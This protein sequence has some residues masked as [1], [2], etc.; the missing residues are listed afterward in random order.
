MGAPPPVKLATDFSDD[1]ET[2]LRESPAHR[3]WLAAF[4]IDTYQ[5]SNERYQTFVSETGHESPS[6]SLNP[7]LSLPSHPV[8]GISWYDAAAYAAW[9]G[10][11]LPTEAEWEKAARGDLEQQTYPWGNQPNSGKECNAADKQSPCPWKDDSIDDGFPFTAPVGSYPPNEYGLYDM[12][13]NVWEWC[14]DDCRRYDDSLGNNPVGPLTIDRRAIRGGSWS[15]SAFD[16]RCSR[17]D[18]RIMSAYGE[19]LSNVG[20]RCAASPGDLFQS[21]SAL[22]NRSN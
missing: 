20:F 13:G 9:A 7:L 22:S 4:Y 10:K 14:Y 17:R 11:R 6:F 15:G 16:L 12:A 8:V 5:V 21:L 1:L 19:A 2:R 3:I 18:Q